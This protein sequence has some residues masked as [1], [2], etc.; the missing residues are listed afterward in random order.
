MF[1]EIGASVPSAYYDARSPNLPHKA[2]GGWRVCSKGCAGKA[3][4]RG[5]IDVAGTS[6]SSG[7]A[8]VAP[9]MST[10]PESEL[11]PPS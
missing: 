4:Q 10:N 11:T 1:V 8:G 9:A 7:A 6:K 2:P 5:G 3:T